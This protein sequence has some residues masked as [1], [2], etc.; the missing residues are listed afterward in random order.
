LLKKRKKR[1]RVWLKWQ[2]IDIACVRPCVQPPVRQKKKEK[3]QNQ[4]FLEIQQLHPELEQEKNE[5]S[6]EHLAVQQSKREIKE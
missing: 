3:K 5:I 1:L 2:G 6:L 4:G